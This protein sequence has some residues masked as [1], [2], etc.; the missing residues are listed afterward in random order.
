M[1]WESRHSMEA[2]ITVLSI[3]YKQKYFRRTCHIFDISWKIGTWT[4]CK[5]TGRHCKYFPLTHYSPMLLFYTP[6]KHRKTKRFS[7]VFRGYRKATPGCNGLN[8]MLNI[9]FHNIC[10]CRFK[11]KYSVRFKETG[12]F[13]LYKVNLRIALSLSIVHLS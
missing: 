11:D 4:W 13:N 8:K 12:Q 2:L 1:R 5:V 9:D 6:W 10:L 7:D 3:F